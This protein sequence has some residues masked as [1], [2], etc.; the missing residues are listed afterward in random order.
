MLARVLLYS[1]NNEAAMAERLRKL[2]FSVPRSTHVS[3]PVNLLCLDLIGVLVLFTGATYLSSGEL[4]V[5]KAMAIGLLVAVNHVLA[6][7]FAVLPKQL[8]GFA[9]I[10]RANERPVLAYLISSF[11][12]FTVSVPLSYG[13]Y[14]LRLHVSLGGPIL[15]F[16]AQCKWLLLSTILAFALAFECDDHL[17]EFA[18]PKWLRWV[19]GA[20]LAALL[21]LTGVLVMQWLAPDQLQL[22]PFDPPPKLWLPVALSAGIGAL[23]GATIPHWY[24]GSVRK[25]GT[26]PPFATPP[27][28]QTVT[29]SSGR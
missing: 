9:D 1:C 15:P 7:T 21:A 28:A 5:G 2:G 8:W 22:H 13:F 17:R 26:E 12:A 4:G 11:C 20:G 27:S 18:T 10:R 19:E 23:F 25:V 14:L 16:A 29:L 3:L 24:R 6:A